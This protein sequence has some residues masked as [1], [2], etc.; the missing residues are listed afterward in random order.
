MKLMIVE[1]PA[2]C[3]SIQGYLGE[4][5]QV[6]ASFGHIRDLPQKQM[7]VDLVTFKPQYEVSSRSKRNVNELKRLASTAD[8]VVLATDP[9]REGESIS[10]HLK[11][12]L[13]LAQGRYSRV[14]FNEI[15]RK[16]IQQALQQASD[17]DY[18]LVKAQ[19]A[20]RVIDRLVGY[21]VTPAISNI[22]GSWITAGRV[23]SVAVRLVVERDITIRD[24]KPMDYYEVVLN[25]VTE[26]QNWYAKW[27]IQPYLVG[28]ATHI[29]QR[30]LAEQIAQVRELRV[31][32]F[33]K[34]QR[35]RNPYAPFITSTLQQAASSVL[36]ISPKQCMS[37][38]QA[39]FEAGMITYHRTDN[40]NLSEDGY[41][42]VIDWL[43][44]H[45]YE[46][47]AVASQ[48]TWKTKKN[49]QEGHEAIRPVD[50]VQ[51][52]GLVKGTIDEDQFAVYQLI[53]Q[54]AVASQMKAAVY[55]VTEIILESKLVIEGRAPRFMA[56]GS[57]EV[58]AGWMLI[59]NQLNETN[60]EEEDNQSLPN[61][62]AGTA[63]TATDGQVLSKKTKPPARFTE[64][65]L[66]KK[67]EDEGVG[68]PSTYASILENIVK[69]QYVKLQKRT[70][71]ATETG[72][73]IYGLLKEKFRFFEVSYTSSVE[74]RL[75][76]IAHRQDSYET[77]IR[78]VYG[79]LSQE[80]IT[81][82]ARV[83]DNTDLNQQSTPRAP[84]DET[85]PCEC[86]QGFYQLR[87]GSKGSFFGCSAYPKCRHTKEV[88]EG[89][90]VD[91]KPVNSQPKGQ[92]V[93][94]PTC[95]SGN[96]VKRKVK[97]GK[98]KDKLFHGCSLYPNCKHFAWIDK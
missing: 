82:G 35:K 20:R 58:Y 81:L 27:M 95:H 74:D 6:K 17:I 61:I 97:S 93:T 98:N 44:T 32:D 79:Q 3:K 90:P 48:N 54:R 76:K 11:A 15:S 18:A 24:F 19:E 83:P 70:L 77:L 86:G 37:I 10:W 40:P 9:D 66:V 41:Q 30:D 92:V 4:G 63:L 73:A 38:A 45:G 13:A 52:P 25:F 2:K 94:C 59:E 56:K 46:A 43:N 1:S 28:D 80:L 71:I 89:K 68:R 60:D 7:G 84:I 23:Q 21:A 49:A 22:H 53:W 78:E 72:F 16:A 96:L 34:S 62:V 31:V 8:H 65:S 75:D 57:T 47:H 26:G 64:A 88:M 12:T 29:Q 33:A 14:S 87:S 85:Y 69:R 67:L 51:D 91:K 36:K 39:L 55:D 5:W 42:A 50:I